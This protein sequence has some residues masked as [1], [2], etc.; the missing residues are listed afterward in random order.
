ML[1]TRF[2]RSPQSLSPSVFVLRRAPFSS[3][4]LARVSH[5]NLLSRLQLS[6]C[7]NADD[8]HDVALLHARQETENRGV[9]RVWRT[10]SMRL[11]LSVSTSV[12]HTHSHTH[13]FSLFLPR[14]LLSFALTLTSLASQLR[15]RTEKLGELFSW[16]VLH[17]YYNN[18][19]NTALK[20]CYSA[21]S[22]YGMVRVLPW[23]AW[24]FACLFIC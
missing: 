6:R 14:F 19:R 10:I 3:P 8:K 17:E 24:E 7:Y 11:S 1:F 21:F 2:S 18:A 15:N 12:T 13:T 9:R 22:G 20:R 4:V 16:T 23:C 5:F